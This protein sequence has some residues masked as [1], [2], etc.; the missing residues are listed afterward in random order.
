MKQNKKT[1]SIKFFQKYFKENSDIHEF[2]YCTV[3][4]NH[5]FDYNY[6]KDDILKII[7]NF[8]EDI[9]FKIMEQFIKISF[10]G[11]NINHFLEYLLLGYCK[12]D[13]KQQLKVFEENRSL[14]L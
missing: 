1:T 5:V 6:T 7:L 4:E 2:S 11:G 3:V 9:R 10:A 12:E 14:Y 8:S 13:I